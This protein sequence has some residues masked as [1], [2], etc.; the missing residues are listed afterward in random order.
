MSAPLVLPYIIIGWMGYAFSKTTKKLLASL[1]EEHQPLQIIDVKRRCASPHFAPVRLYWKFKVVFAIINSVYSFIQ[2]NRVVVYQFFETC[3]QSEGSPLLL[4]I[5]ELKPVTLTLGI[6]L[7]QTD[8]FVS[9]RIS[10]RKLI[11]YCI[12]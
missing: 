12:N 7:A 9:G 3:W 8:S 10:Q 5:T 2:Q 1:H 4:Q 11:A 6:C